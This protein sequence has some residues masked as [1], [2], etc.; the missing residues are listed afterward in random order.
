MNNYADIT[1]EKRRMVRAT[2]PTLLSCAL[3]CV[4]LPMLCACRQEK[5]Q[6]EP[7][8]H[9]EEKVARLPVATARRSDLPSQT[10]V[11]GVASA[12][13]DH[14]VMI[15][16]H[17]AGKIDRLAIVPGQHVRQEEV[18]AVLDDTE[19]VAQLK[20]ATTP[21]KTAIA[22]VTQAQA[23]L[24]FALKEA[25][26]LEDLFS[27]DLAAK[28]DIIAAQT[29]VE[30][31]KAKLQAVKS[32]LQEVESSS[33]DLKAKLAFTRVRTPIA[34]VV[35]ERF[36]NI[37]DETDPSKPIAHVID[38]REIA[39]DAD[40][41]ADRPNRIKVGQTGNVRTVADAERVYKGTV[42]FVSPIVDKQKNTVKV[43][44][45]CANADGGLKEGQTVTVSLLTSISRGAL[46]I[47][48]SAIVPDPDDP[49]STAVYVVHDGKSKRIPVVVGLSSGDR[50]E[51]KAGLKEG[52]T[53]IASG[54]YG[55][56]DGVT[57]EPAGTPDK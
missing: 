52:E 49:A 48:K 23:E 27:H 45:L 41:P 57:I 39:V 37:G 6:V 8:E 1:K 34:G 30:T 25:T 36:L 13:P 40:V 33:L 53:V 22:V 9:E 24:D 26:R 28:K 46:T 11:P 20:A 4:L 50:V 31:S 51:I 5:T 42:I 18:V 56:P 19:L 29:L 47:P 44:L 2:C 38:L 55:L 12:L 7:A 16:P 15:A 14:S 3:C 35:A 17:V 21:E 32:K 43:R 10:T 54:S